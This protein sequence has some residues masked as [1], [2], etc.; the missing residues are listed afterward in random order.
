V[1]H[2]RLRLLSF[3]VGVQLVIIKKKHTEDAR[4]LNVAFHVLHNTTPSF[5]ILRTNLQQTIKHT[6]KRKHIVHAVHLYL[7]RQLF[8]RSQLTARKEHNM[9]RTYRQIAGK[10]NH[11]CCKVYILSI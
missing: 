4:I 8:L 11:K 7:D 5:C 10:Y 9:F 6:Q 3:L 1:T 2:W